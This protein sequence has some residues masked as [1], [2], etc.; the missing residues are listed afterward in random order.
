MRTYDRGGIR[1]AVVLLRYCAGRVGIDENS[2]KRNAPYLA[3]GGASAAKAKVQLEI[4][5]GNVLGQWDK[6]IT[7]DFSISK[8]GLLAKEGYLVI[9]WLDLN[10]NKINDQTTST[11]QFTPES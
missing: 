2:L 10:G 6:A 4:T 11:Y 3:L 7:D 9:S 8:T 5:A 1:V